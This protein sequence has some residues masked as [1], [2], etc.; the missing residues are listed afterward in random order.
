M[1]RYVYQWKIPKVLIFL[2]I[3]GP[4]AHA[5]ALGGKNSLEVQAEVLFTRANYGYVASLLENRQELKETQRFILAESL[6]RLGRLKEAQASYQG[7]LSSADEALKQKVHAR[8]FQIVLIED[9]VKGAINLFNDYKKLYKKTPPMMNY[10]L[11]KALYDKNYKDQ[12]L[13]VLNLVPKGNEFYIRAQY[14]IATLTIDKGSLKKSIE[15]YGA[16]EKEKP[17]SVEDYSIRDM[18][19]LAQAR[20]YGDA[21]RED[22]AAAAY[23]R[24]PLTGAYGDSATVELLKTLIMRGEMAFNAEG[25]YAKLSEATR[26]RIT[27][28]AFGRA[29]RA[30]ERYRKNSKIDWQKP[31]LHALMALLYVKSQRYDEGRVAYKELIEHYRPI[32][33]NLVETK[34]NETPWPIFALNF[35]QPGVPMKS[36]FSGVPDRLLKPID[37]IQNLLSLKSSIEE[38]RRHLNKLLASG[39]DNSELEK[40]KNNQLIIEKKYENLVKARQKN[41]NLLVAQG[42]NE[43]IAQAEFRRAELAQSEMRDLKIQLEAN[44]NF[45]TKKNNDFDKD[46]LE[47]DKGGSL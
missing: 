15:L 8:L 17:I 39:F 42:I 25:K 38:K 34:D 11:G 6:F 21:G 7:L 32:Y 43:V 4:C 36:L 1:L 10:A 33:E 9:D 5:Q 18:A 26:Q 46:L 41:I 44:R 2:G 19:I 13:I 28:E 40:A 3:A 22:L 31:E 12:A 16:I 37:E 35:E 45:Q 14:L 20:I 24:V 47:L 29:S 27:R 23:E 30:V